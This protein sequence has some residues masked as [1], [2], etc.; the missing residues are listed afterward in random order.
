[1][2]KESSMTKKAIAIILAF[3]VL[4]GTLALAQG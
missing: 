2:E 3:P 1:M 4:D